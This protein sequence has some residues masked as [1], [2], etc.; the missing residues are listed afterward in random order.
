MMSTITIT[1]TYMAPPLASVS[2][3]VLAAGSRYPWW[4]QGKHS[5]WDLQPLGVGNVHLSGHGEGDKPFLEK[6]DLARA[7]RAV[8]VGDDLC[9]GRL[10]AGGTRQPTG[11]SDP[12][13]DHPALEVVASVGGVDHARR[14]MGVAV[15]DG[16]GCHA[17][18]LVG[19][20]V[21]APGRVVVLERVLEAGL[22]G[23]VTLEKALSEVA[24]T[25][26]LDAGN[27]HVGIVPLSAA[28][29][30]W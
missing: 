24:L 3:G 11:V 12:H 25:G 13:P 17:Y 27:V 28:G 7:V 10:A 14:Q 1:G 23:L 21:G 26:G 9:T 5:A 22:V 4:R 8:G 30:M 18:Q 29:G 16:G 15:V 2:S 20:V 19:L 6:V